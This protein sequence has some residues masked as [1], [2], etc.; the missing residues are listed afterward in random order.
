MLKKKLISYLFVALSTG[1][2]IDASQPSTEQEPLGSVASPLCSNALSQPQEQIALKLIDDICGD[3]WCSGDYNFAFRH[4]TC[5]G[6]RGSH[7]GS[8]RLDLQIIPREGVPTPRASFNRSCTTGDF[9]S[10]DSLVATAPSGYQSL[11]PAYYDALTE[12]TMTLEA[13]LPH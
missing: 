2:A 1:C 12:C 13:A 7:A 5:T 3:T 6:P 11:Q 9:Q 8:C 10:F 4:L